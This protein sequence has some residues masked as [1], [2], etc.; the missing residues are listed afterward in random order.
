MVCV[1]L[2][3]GSKNVQFHII[4]GHSQV[5]HNINATEVDPHSD[6]MHNGTVKPKNRVEDGFVIE[7][8]L[9]KTFLFRKYENVIVRKDC[10]E[11]R[12]QT[13]KPGDWVKLI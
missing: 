9:R 2:V 13:P 8:Q 11:K 6:S 1:G 10:W 5:Q 4:Y 3:F 12:K 7:L